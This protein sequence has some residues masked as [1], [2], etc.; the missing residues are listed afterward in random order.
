MLLLFLF[1]LF[2]GFYSYFIAD[3]C[4][5]N[6]DHP[7][8][9]NI[10][11][12]SCHKCR[13]NFFFLGGTY[14]PDRSLFSRVQTTVGGGLPLTVQDISAVSPADRVT[15]PV[16]PGTRSTVNPVTTGGVST[17]RLCS[18]YSRFCLSLVSANKRSTPRKRLLSPE[19]YY[20]KTQQGAGLPRNCLS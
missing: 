3:S 8:F 14:V 4:G 10:C 2:E 12:K 17:S 6:I 1:G 11:T 18:I 20:T 16:Y 13:L 9:A 19:K 15:G 7:P 5:Q